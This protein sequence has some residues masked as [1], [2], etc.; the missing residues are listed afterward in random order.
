VSA[1]TPQ[2]SWP[3][4]DAAIDYTPGVVL[5]AAVALGWR[6]VATVVA[7][8]AVIFVLVTGGLLLGKII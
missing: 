3:F 5:S 4:A 8:S 1:Q 7:S 2:A 6:H